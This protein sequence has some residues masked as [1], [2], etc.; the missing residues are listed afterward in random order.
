MKMKKVDHDKEHDIV[1]VQWWNKKD[2]HIGW[3][4][5]LNIGGTTIIVDRNKKGEVRALE[6]I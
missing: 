1:T 2:E 5:E 4:E 3:S 6:I